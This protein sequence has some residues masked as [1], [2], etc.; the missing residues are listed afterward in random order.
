[1]N[2]NQGKARR[3][4]THEKVYWLCTRVGGRSTHHSSCFEAPQAVNAQ[5][6][7]GGGGSNLADR[8]AALEAALCEHIG[9][10][11]GNPT[12]E[13]IAFC[14]DLLFKTVFVTSST[15]TGDLKTEGGGATGLEGADNICNLRAQEAGL[16]GTYTAWLSDSSTDAKERVTQSAIQYERTD[17]VVVVDDFADLTDCTNPDC[18]QAPIDRD[19][20]AT[21]IVGLLAIW[22]GTDA[23]GAADGLH[24]LSDCAGTHTHIRGTVGLRAIDIRWT[25]T[26]EGLCQASIFH[27][28]CF[29]D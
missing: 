29:Q 17:G 16:P 21:P 23:T 10:L 20:S 25:E 15:H 12:A 1:M 7:G 3:I 19:E 13:E 14:G 9:A 2:A 27:I 8:V 28:Y 6:K 18:L 11:A 4:G 24:C 5:G 26:A 22:T